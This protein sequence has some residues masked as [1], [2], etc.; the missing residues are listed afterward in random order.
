M[1]AAPLMSYLEIGEEMQLPAHT[2]ST[3]LVADG[4]ADSESTFS[5]CSRQLGNLRLYVRWKVWSSIGWEGLKIRR[6][7]Q[8]IGV[9]ACCVQIRSSCPWFWASPR[10]LWLKDRK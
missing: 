1:L 3:L 5:I 2:W 4:P 7:A 9:H 8:T 10:A 6:R